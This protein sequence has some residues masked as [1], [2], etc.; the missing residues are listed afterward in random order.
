MSK[1]ELVEFLKDNLKVEVSN[2]CGGDFTVSLR[3]CG[4]IISS[5]SYQA[6]DSKY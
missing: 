4:E 3:L 2:D 6:V 1:E 5:D